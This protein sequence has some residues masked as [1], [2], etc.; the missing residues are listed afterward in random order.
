MTTTNTNDTTATVEQC[1]RIIEAGGELV[2]ITAQGTKE[3]ANLMNIKRDIALKGYSAPLVA[4]IHFN[5][6]AALEAAKHIAKVRIN[7]GNYADPRAK[8]QKVEFTN[9]EYQAEL[10]RIEERLL[11]LIELCKAN[12]VA[13]R[14][15][16]NHG[17]L[18]DRIMSRFGDS[19]RGMAESAME[20]LRI[21]RRNGYNS[22]VVSMKA[23]NTQ[24]MVQATR[25]LVA[26]MDAEGMSYPLHLGVTEAGD[27]E[28]GRIKSAVGIGA[29]LA[30]GIGDTIRV[31]L[32]EE[33]ELEIPVAIELV[34]HF[35][36]RS[37]SPALDEPSTLPFDPYTY[38]RRISE[39]VLSIGASNPPVVMA[40]LAH[41]AEVTQQSIEQC[42]WTFTN[43]KWAQS[44][45]GADFIHI[46]SA[47]IQGVTGAE[48]LPIVSQSDLGFGYRLIDA[49]GL[50]AAKPATPVFVGISYGQLTADVVAA[51]KSNPYAV[52]V[53]KP[54]NANPVAELKASFIKLLGEKVLNPVVIALDFA[55]QQLSQLQIASAADFGSLLIDG[56]GDGIMISAPKVDTASVVSTAFSI[57][58]A[59]RTRIS[60][61][62]YISCPGCGRTL[63]SLQETLARIRAKTSHIKGLKIGVMGCIVNGPGEMADADYGYVGAGPGKISLYK[64]KEVVRKSIPEAEAVDALIAL[65]K[66]NGDWKD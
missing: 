35:A 30:D 7:P 39:G 17:S 60:K 43:G 52:V 46:G 62:E 4:D 59:T 48:Q 63:F 31:S 20:F 23:S 34:N 61:T 8:F 47:K 27:G 49:D 21:C 24:V 37:T 12:S 25:L 51:L 55:S 53:L 45:M 33:P 15:G 28:D 38:N 66:E 19:P 2:R 56:F 57:L 6:A 18:S 9:E 14:I 65:I 26:L 64:S 1:I 11:P 13:M 29:L 50:P 5:P 54:T 44:D 41:L 40:N 42:G 3:A 36:N 10:A 22:V 58:Q 16:V 32:T